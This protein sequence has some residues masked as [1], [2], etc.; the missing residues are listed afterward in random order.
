MQKSLRAHFAAEQYV[1]LGDQALT[2]NLTD[3]ETEVCR[4]ARAMYADDGCPRRTAEGPSLPFSRPPVSEARRMYDLQ[5]KRHP[6]SKACKPSHARRDTS[7][8]W[9]IR[10]ITSIP[11]PNG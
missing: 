11:H 3:S 9:G 8:R 5:L 1:R 10:F 2:N 7:N 4:R 6:E